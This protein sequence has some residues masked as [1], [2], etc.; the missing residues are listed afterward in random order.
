MKNR[1]LYELKY[2]TPGQP[3]Q[4]QPK[5]VQQFIDRFWSFPSVG[6]F[7]LEVTPNFLS[8]GPS[9]R[10]VFHWCFNCS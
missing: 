2:P 1:K 8:Y 9:P 10:K 6:H 7:L 4:I 5:S 3:L